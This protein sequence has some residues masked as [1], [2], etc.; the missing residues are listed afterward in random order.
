ML[1]VDQLVVGEAR[2]GGHT[3]RREVVA[4]LHLGAGGRPL[5]DGGAEHGVQVVDPPLPLGEALVGGPLGV[6][7]GLD[8]L[9]EVVLP[10]DLDDEPAVRR[11]EPVHDQRPQVAVAQPHGPEVG[12]DVGDG[13]QGVEHGDVDLLALAGGVAVA[14]GGQHADH[15]EQARADVAQ[16][17]HGGHQWWR[18]ALTL[19]LVDARHGLGDRGVGRPAVVGRAGGPEARHRQVHGPGRHRRDVGPAQAHAVQR[20]GLEVL[21]H[22][23][24]PGGQVQDHL[25]ALGVLEVH[26]DRALV[27][28]VA[29]ERGPHPPALG[30]GHGRQRRPARVAPLG[31]LHL[32]HLGAEP[33]QELGGVGQRLH[34]LEGQHPHPVERLAVAHCALVGDVTQLHACPCSRS[35]RLQATTF[36]DGPSG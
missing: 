16:A 5:L 9:G 8:Q 34:L 3:R 6:A 22:H 20:A 4:R 19:E 11:P 12:H 23:V 1:V 17:T 10:P 32:D 27:Q 26:A 15:R 7:D 35:R 13:H 14:Q 36:P 25:A 24:E 21:G 2:A 33:G 29:Q 18:V 31:V 30:V 28:V